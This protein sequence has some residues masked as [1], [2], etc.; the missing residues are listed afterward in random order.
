MRYLVAAAALC[1]GTTLG[2]CK[3]RELPP[4]EGSYA[5]TFDRDSIGGDYNATGPG[6]RIVDGALEARGAHNHPLWLARK[7]PPG[8][9]QI[10]FDAWSASLDGDIKV[11]VFGDG[12][13]YDPD[14]NRY[15][16]TSYVLVFGAWKNS[17]SIIARMDEHAKDLLSRADKRVVVNQRY[18][19][20]IVRKGQ[21]LEW[22]L[23]DMTTPFLRL[24]D[25]QPLVGPG[26]EYFGFNDWETPVY[27]DNLVIK[28]P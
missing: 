1:A 10:D 6:Y 16:A 14:G 20:R 19:W 3:V 17:R 27:F 5:D 7:L 23:D 18:H 11:E 4:I 26:H 21:V 28:R 2:G 15:M 13:S 9:L 22:F 8:D 12:R 24:D 25:P